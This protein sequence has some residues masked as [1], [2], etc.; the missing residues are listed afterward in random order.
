[1]SKK[2][3]SFLICVIGFWGTGIAWAQEKDSTK[4]A[5][6]AKTTAPA[7]SPSPATETNQSAGY[8]LKLKALEQR[9][10][11][12]KER[13]FRSKARLNL[14][15]E[16]VLH[17]KIMGSRAI[18][19][20]KNEVGSTYRLIQVLYAVDGSEIY[21]KKD[22]S[23][24]LNDKKEFEVFNGSI[25]P[26]NHTISVVM[27]LR[28]HGYGV[29]SYMEGYNFTAKNSHTF[30][31]GEGRRTVVTTR[32]CEKGNPVTTNMQDRLEVKFNTSVSAAGAGK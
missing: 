30:T 2:S 18:I 23:G 5:N 21:S 28:G 24:V 14:L 22:D 26:G 6:T 10:N 32:L 19:K 12:L 15:K 1:M 9:V 27:R 13:I 29:F 17:R 4:P 11:E 7:T 31:A 25:T 3:F 8:R 20:H 16:T